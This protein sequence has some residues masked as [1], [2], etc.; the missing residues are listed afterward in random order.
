M[1]FCQGSTHAISFCS[2]SGGSSARLPDSALS[3]KLNDMSI[4]ERS[5]GLDDLHG[6]PGLVRETPEMLKE[7]SQEM[8]HDL[9]SAI[10]TRGGEESLP[11]RSAVEM[12]PEYV[13]GLKICFLRAENYH[14]KLAANRMIS[15]FDQKMRLF[16]KDKL[17]REIRL[18]DLGEDAREALQKGLIQALS[19]RDR[20]GRIILLA[21]GAVS[22]R[23][24]IKSC[25]S[26]C[27]EMKTCL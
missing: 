22:S 26:P 12:S 14:S 5:H 24:E 2:P 7:K 8:R 20:A 15:F 25:V 19:L 18:D 27:N 3:A 17:V 13:N 6:I 9:I 4:E 16:G 10:S 21:Y 23:Y 1:E 11:Y